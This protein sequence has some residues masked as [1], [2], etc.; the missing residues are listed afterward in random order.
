MMTIAHQ[1]EQIGWQRGFR[2][3]FRE[4]F[5]EGLREGRQLTMQEALRLL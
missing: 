4:G 5:R 1:F 2:E 3:D